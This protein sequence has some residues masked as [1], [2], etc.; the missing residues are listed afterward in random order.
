[1]VIWV[2]NKMVVERGNKQQEIINLSDYA[3]PDQDLWMITTE[4]IKKLPILIELK[5]IRGHQDSNK[6]G[7]RIFGPFSQEVQMNLLVNKLANRDMKL[8]RSQATIRPNLHNAVMSVYDE[9]GMA[10]LDMRSYMTKRIN[11]GKM[12]DY[13]KRRRQWDDVTV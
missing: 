1:M 12:L 10:I 6:F 5:W 9:N 3:A 7:E 2:D 4:L 8:D 11:G 13:L